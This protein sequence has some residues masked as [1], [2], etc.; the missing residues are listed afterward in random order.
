DRATVLWRT[1]NR[2]AVLWR[3]WNRAKELRR[4]RNCTEGLKGR[5]WRTVLE[6]TVTLRRHRENGREGCGKTGPSPSKRWCG[7]LRRGA[8]RR[9]EVHIRIHCLIT[10]LFPCVGNDR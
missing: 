8:L 3:T 10:S 7:C 1:W 5:R 9:I 2:A 4:T 6:D